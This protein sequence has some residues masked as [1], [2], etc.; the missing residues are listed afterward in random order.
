MDKIRYW[1][2]LVLLVLGG[3]TACESY[4]IG[5]LSARY[6]ADTSPAS[7]VILSN[8]ATAAGLPMADYCASYGLA[9]I[10]L[11]EVTKDID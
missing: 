6:C 7:R 10:V 1:T 2:L 9:F 3:M 8:M 5:G 11:G 4:D